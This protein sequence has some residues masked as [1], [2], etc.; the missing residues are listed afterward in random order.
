[1]RLVLRQGCVNLRQLDLVV[2]RRLRVLLKSLGQ[3]VMSLVSLLLCQVTVRTVRSLRMQVLVVVRRL[4]M[5]LWLGREVLVL[6]LNLSPPLLLTR[7]SL[8]QLLLFTAAP[9]VM[10]LSLHMQYHPQPITLRP[11]LTLEPP[12]IC[13]M[14]TRLSPHIIHCQTTLSLWLTILPHQH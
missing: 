7:L 12:T 2:L 13:G 8:Y 1:M 11:L 6:V 14:I 4:L 10:S 5:R 3:P 9:L